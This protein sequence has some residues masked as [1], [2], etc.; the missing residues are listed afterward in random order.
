MNSRTCLY[1][2]IIFLLQAWN[3]GCRVV[4]VP[5]QM[6]V[7]YGFSGFCHQSLTHKNNIMMGKACYWADNECSCLII[8]PGLWIAISIKHSD[9]HNTSIH[10]YIE[11]PFWISISLWRLV[12]P[13]TKETC[14]VVAFFLLVCSFLFSSSFWP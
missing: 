4:V 1:M 3:A 8:Y 10:L 5:S 12:Q 9:S 14:F 6:L 13:L 2:K 7:G 11:T